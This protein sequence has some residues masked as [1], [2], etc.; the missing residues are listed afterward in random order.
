MIYYYSPKCDKKYG[1]GITVVREVDFK[2]L[3]G[4]YCIAIDTETTGLDPR[5][6]KLIC[7]QLYST[8]KDN[9]V[10]VKMDEDIVEQLRDY[11]STL[12]TLLFHNMKFDIPFLVNAGLVD[13]VQ[14]LDRVHCTFI[15]HQL[16]ADGKYISL[17]DCVEE[18]I[19]D[20]DMD[21]SVRTEFVDFDLTQ[22]LT[23]AQL[24]YCSSDVMYLEE[25]TARQI[26]KMQNDFGYGHI[27]PL[28]MNTAIVLAMI[29]YNGMLIDRERWLA[30][31]DKYRPIAAA[32][33]DALNKEIVDL[34]LYKFMRNKQLSLF[35]PNN[36]EVYEC[37]V[38]WDSPTNVRDVLLE[39]GVDLP[40]GSSDSDALEKCT[41]NICPKILNYRQA[42]KILTTYGVSFLDNNVGEDGRIHCVYN[43]LG[44]A[45]GRIISNKPNMQ[46]IPATAEF[47]DCF[48]ASPGYKLVVA[49]Y[50]QI[51]IRIAADICRDTNLIEDFKNNLDPY[52]EIGKRM[53]NKPVSKKENTYLRQI[54]KTIMLGLNYGMGA[55]KLA[56]KLNVSK[57]VAQ[58]YINKFRAA[59][60]QLSQGLETLGKMAVRDRFTKT[61]S[62][63]NRVRKFKD[64]DPDDVI[65]RAGKNTP[66]QGTNADII[67]LALCE[68]FERL[69]RYNAKLVNTV[70]DEIVVECIESEAEE[71]AKVIESAMIG[72]AGV[73]LHRCPVACTVEVSDRWLK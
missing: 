27:I 49:D 29:Q 8:L 41:H 44:A 53:F 24:K 40:N 12:T 38:N 26:I 43:Q 48:V 15:G 30:V 35:E 50:S 59:M 54:A 46:N 34:K 58:N 66:I 16:L 7:V 47:R 39:L 71:V 9:T 18:Y 55:S 31:S 17:A 68:I 13:P 1:F 70:H 14:L 5:T 23:E 63:I 45:T 52:S 57:S 67:K 4:D 28:E 56:D 60:P 25:V 42:K 64:D 19:G 72:A 20:I 3:L 62:P 73:I 32:Y 10:V 33:I 11:L 65:E 69:S 22:D 37:T 2:D 21:K 36:G 51:E 6:D 61:A